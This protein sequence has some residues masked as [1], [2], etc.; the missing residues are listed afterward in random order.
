MWFGRAE[1]NSKILITYDS[2][3]LQSLP[4]GNMKSHT[5]NKIIIREKKLKAVWAWL[6]L[7]HQ[8]K[9]ILKSWRFY[10]NKRNIGKG[11]SKILSF[12]CR[13]IAPFRDHNFLRIRKGS[14]QLKLSLYKS[15]WSHLLPGTTFKIA[16]N[17]EI[18]SV[19]FWRPPESK[20]RNI[21]MVC[22]SRYMWAHL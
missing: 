6:T 17:V 14:H 19:K 11:S 8:F 7:I 20:I 22:N 3:P 9:Q 10:T 4:S 21:L 18:I 15:L 5:R 12:H 2:C 13:W 16:I 1:K